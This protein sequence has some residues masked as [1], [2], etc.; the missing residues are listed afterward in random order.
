MNL[1]TNNLQPLSQAIEAIVATAKDR[2]VAIRNAS[3]RHTSGFVW[4]PDV[5]VASEQTIGERDE[6][7]IVT[8]DGRSTR[9][10]II[11]RDAGTNIL[12]MRPSER[13]DVSPSSPALPR[14]GGLVLA[15]AAN[16]DGTTAVRV[17]AVRSVGDRWFSRAGGSI[18]QRITLDIRLHRTEEGGPVV[19]AAGALVGMS[20]LGR[21]GEVLAIPTATLTRVV[22]QLVANGRVARGWL[23][24][25][26]QPI[27]VPDALVDQAGQRIAMMVMSIAE[28]GPAAK[29]GVTA[30]DI[31]LTVDSIALRGMRQ[32]VA[33]LSEENI[34]Q[35]VELR[36]I[37]GGHIIKLAAQIGIRP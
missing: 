1:E 20:T 36:L 2:V 4:Q 15:L 27:A 33:R 22:P 37:R 31:L 5:I 19:D 30:G 17:G 23:G 12:V 16:F 28:H 7:E 29:A 3:H 13:I 6:Y 9:A 11:G 21:P 26:L 25:A 24:V 18:D 32:L 35:S 14:I 10:Q 34:G 8:A